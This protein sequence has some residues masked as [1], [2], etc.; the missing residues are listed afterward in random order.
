LLVAGF[1]LILEDLVSVSRQHGL[2]ELLQTM[3]P[4]NLP[5]YRAALGVLVPGAAVAVLGQ[6]LIARR[7][8]HR[9]RRSTYLSDY[10]LRC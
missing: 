3:S 4:L 6:W 9:R 1:A 2:G 7:R 8:R 5:Y 10:M